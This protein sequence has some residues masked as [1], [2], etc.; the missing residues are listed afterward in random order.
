[1]GNWFLPVIL[2]STANV[3]PL[4]VQND[5]CQAIDGALLIN[6]DDEYIGKL[7]GST[8]PDSVFNEYG[9]YGNEYN[10]RSIWNKYG[11]NGSEYQ[12]GSAFNDYSSD[13]PRIVKGGNVIGLLTTNKFK[14]GAINPISIGVVC[15]EF[16]PP[17]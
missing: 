9:K 15:Y 14:R 12:A 3:P 17:R 10:P 13:P 2:A 8:D 4:F 7:A 16:K 11:K 5:V 1:M 6:K